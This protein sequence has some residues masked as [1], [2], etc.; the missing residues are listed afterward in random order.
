LPWAVEPEERSVPVAQ[1]KPA[2]SKPEAAPELA[3]L[4]AL[5]ELPEPF[6]LCA[7]GELPPGVPTAD[8]LLPALETLAVLLSVPQAV[9]P[10]VT[11]AASAAANNVVRVRRVVPVPVA[12]VRVVAFTVFLSL[13]SQ[14]RPALGGPR[15]NLPA[16]QTVGTAG[17]GCGSAR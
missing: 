8:E 17:G 13:R 11:A 14:C 2:A 15:R 1:V 5:L 10:T 4:F 3:G 12:F 16:A 9:R 7:A 6:E